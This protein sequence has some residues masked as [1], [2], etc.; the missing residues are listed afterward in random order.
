MLT[1]TSKPRSHDEYPPDDGRNRERGWKR[2]WTCRDCDYTARRSEAAVTPRCPKHGERMR[3]RPWTYK[4][5]R[6]R[7]AA[8]LLKD[9]A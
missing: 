7:A 4:T 8:K 2:T 6:Q 1:R 9:G 5:P 3:Q